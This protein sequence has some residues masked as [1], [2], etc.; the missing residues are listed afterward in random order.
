MPNR[1]NASIE[2]L[3]AHAELTAAA[4]ATTPDA[5]ASACSIAFVDRRVRFDA[6]CD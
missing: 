2:R 6:R 4:W 3:P 1:F 5:R